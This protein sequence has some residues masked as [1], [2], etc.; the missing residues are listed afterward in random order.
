MQIIQLQDTLTSSIGKSSAGIHSDKLATADSQ[1]KADPN[2][3]SAS[4]TPA[5]FHPSTD[6]MLGSYGRSARRMSYAAMPRRVAAFAPAPFSGET[7]SLAI[8]T[9]P[10]GEK[11]VIMF[12]VTVNTPF[13]DGV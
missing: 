11:V 9:I 1:P 10:P 12:S 5:V 8:G 6:L 7:V 2:A 3:S 13:P 4:L